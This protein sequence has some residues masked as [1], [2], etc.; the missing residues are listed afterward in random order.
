LGYKP[1]DAARM[2]QVIDAEAKSCEDIIRMA[3]R[4]AIK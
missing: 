4:G 1:Q 2:V 3:L